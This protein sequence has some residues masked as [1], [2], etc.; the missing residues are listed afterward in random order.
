MRHFPLLFLLV[1]F[2]LLSFVV[3]FVEEVS[4]APA[5]VGDSRRK[6]GKFVSAKNEK[7]LKTYNNVSLQITYP[8]KTMT[9]AT[10]F[11]KTKLKIPLRPRINKG[12]T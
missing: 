7:N 1:N 12:K 11:W 4:A 2:L 6:A 3:L 10:N 5:V 9:T 8:T